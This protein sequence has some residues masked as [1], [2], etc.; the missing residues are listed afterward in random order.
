MK[1]KKI[2]IKLREREGTPH[3]ALAGLDEKMCEAVAVGGF[4][5]TRGRDK[6]S[7]EEK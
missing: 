6:E 7:K 4:L 2:E 5:K 3:E 1:G